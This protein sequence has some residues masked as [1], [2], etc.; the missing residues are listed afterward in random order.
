MSEMNE[1]LGELAAKVNQMPGDVSS[2]LD[3]IEKEL[4]ATKENTGIDVAR[5]IKFQG[6]ANTKGSKFSGLTSADVQILHGIMKSTKG[7]PSEEL[8]NAFQHVSKNFI[9]NSKVDAIPYRKATQNEAAAGYGQELI[10]VQYV[11]ELWDA[12]R[13]DS[14]VFG[15]LDSFE[16]L[17]QQAYLPVVADL[18][19]PQFLGENT[20]ENSFLSGTGR[21]GSNRVLVA[22]KK[23]LI[24]QIW[25]YELEE[26]AIIPFLPFVRSQIAA[27]LAFY[28][29]AVI[30]NGDT[31]NAA[32]GNINSDDADPADTKYF[33]AFDGL[34]K[35]GLVD[36]TANATSMGGAISLA[37]I[38]GLRGLMMDKANLID[39]GHPVRSS[40]IIYVCDPQTADKIAQLDQ[41]VTVDKFGPQAGVLNG[42]IG[43]I[44]GS[45][46]ISTMAMG[47]TEAD[48]KISATP[49][50]NTKG[51]LIAFN[52]NAFKVGMKRGV[53]LELER[54]PG[55][56][57][58]RLVASFRLGLGRYSA[59]GA[60]SGL[61]GAAVLY[62]ITV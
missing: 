49:A 11:G 8:E 17:N 16:M 14:R 58:A 54:M 20:T 2:R 1:L 41:V 59:T 23:M 53:T 27:S 35:L 39:W 43:N 51:Q 55:M 28:S 52:R 56:Q 48:G 33:L 3:A 10:G 50:N 9:N 60:A 36:N 47:L 32:T 29:D 22:A 4:R 6:D 38:A 26:D 44:L 21:V 62:N 7:G 40:D 45:P 46:I 5:K 15:L 42:Q 57:Q 13:Q 31:T 30:L 24:N 37:G 34:R 19:E 61:E 25:T 18:P 12:A